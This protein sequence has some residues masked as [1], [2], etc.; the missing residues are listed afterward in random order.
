MDDLEFPFLWLTGWIKSDIYYQSEVVSTARQLQIAIQF[1]N[2][3]A[4]IWDSVYSRTPTQTQRV[5]DEPYASQQPVLPR[6]KSP[7]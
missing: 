6:C 4:D 1:I 2:R 5:A 7:V 3:N